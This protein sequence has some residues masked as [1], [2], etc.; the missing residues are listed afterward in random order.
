MGGVKAV[1]EHCS[2]RAILGGMDRE[3]S[4]AYATF[5]RCVLD[6]VLEN[7]PSRKTSPERILGVAMSQLILGCS[8]G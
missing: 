1:A 2:G 4:V 8:K 3:V 6:A 5:G 7:A